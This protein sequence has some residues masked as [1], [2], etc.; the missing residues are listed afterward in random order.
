MAISITEAVDRQWYFVGADCSAT[1]ANPVQ[2]TYTIE[3]A[4]A[5]DCQLIHKE[6]SAAGYVVAIVFLVIFVAIL[7][8]TTV[9]FYKKSQGPGGMGSSMPENYEQL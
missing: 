4:D 5:I 8:T 7:A 9:I 3:S 1:A 2:M 6:A